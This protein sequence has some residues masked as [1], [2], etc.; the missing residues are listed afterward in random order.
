MKRFALFIF[1]LLLMLTMSGCATSTRSAYNGT[2]Y[3]SSDNNGQYYSS[4]DNGNAYYNYQYANNAAGSTD[5][6]DAYYTYA[7][8]RGSSSQN[9]MYSLASYVSDND[10]AYHEQASGMCDLNKLKSYKKTKAKSVKVKKAKYKKARKVKGKTK[11]RRVK[12]CGCK[13]HHKYG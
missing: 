10:P 12:S 7:V 11:S 5:G 4:Q 1:S 3:Y 6:Q 13:L 8:D 2:T 9:A